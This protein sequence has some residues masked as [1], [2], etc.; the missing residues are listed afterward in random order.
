MGRGQSAEC[1]VVE[2]AEGTEC[3]WVK[4]DVPPRSTVNPTARVEMAGGGQEEEEGDVKLNEGKE[5]EEEHEDD[6]DYEA[7]SSPARRGVKGKRKRKGKGKV[8]RP[9]KVK[10]VR[11]PPPPAV[12]TPTTPTVPPVNAMLGEDVTVKIDNT[13]IPLRSYF[14]LYRG[15]R[16]VGRRGGE[17]CEREGKREEEVTGVGRGRPL[18]SS[19]LEISEGGTAWKVHVDRNLNFSLGGP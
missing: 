12:V 8:G 9:K 14:R 4:L 1:G 7:E 19:A 18:G 3:K 6:G 15:G 11:V 5:A 17:P 10:V 2:A 16:W 13:A